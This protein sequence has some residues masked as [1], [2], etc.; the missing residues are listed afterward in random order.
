M[1]NILITLLI[2][3]LSFSSHAQGNTLKNA[4][5][6]FDVYAFS[7]AASLYEQALFEE[8]NANKHMVILSKLGDC[9]YNISDSKNAAIWYNRAITRFPDIDSEYL[10]KYVQTLRSI[11]K[12]Q[13]ANKILV[14]YK[15]RQKDDS[16]AEDFEFVNL[17][18]L[19][20]PN[21]EKAKQVELTNLNSNTENSDFS[22]YE[23]NGKFFFSSA[24]RI[25]LDWYSKKDKIYKW[26]K[27]PYLN[28]YE[29]TIEKTNG[30]TEIIDIT[31]IPSDSLNLEIQHE[32][33]SALTKDGNT[34]Y[35]TGN[36]VNKQGDRVND[37]RGTSNLMLYRA[38]RIND[39]WEK[40][41]KLPF[42]NVDF[43]TGHPT[44]SPDE[45]TLYFVSDNDKLP[46]A[47]GQTDLYK[48]QIYDDGSFGEVINLKAVNTVHREMF[49]FIAADSTLYFSS[50]GHATGLLDIFKSDILKKADGEPVTRE[51]L[52]APYNSGADD[53]AYFTND[54]G[55]TGY[56]SSNRDGGVGS[57]D[58]YAFRQEDPCEQII[59]GITYGKAI[60]DID[61]K[62]LQ[63]VL[64]ELKD[65]AGNIIAS[66]TSN[67]NGIYVFV[68]LIMKKHIRFLVKK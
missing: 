67:E 15:E 64:V 3:L 32:G 41:E 9:F 63:G 1:K 39:K 49:P 27:E 4:D 29:G 43:S 61:S 37:G 20:D 54:N 53:F 22:G 10:W 42:N 52:G 47:K 62:P 65:Q 50:D 56:F 60:T 44:L 28:V 30:V 2:S 45:N 57:D 68:G 12:Y 24:N 19:L 35:F 11:G 6:A 36:N 40:V 38:I 55:K 26:N 48:V 51:N 59:S 8:K 25:G 21:S 31:K 23:L 33:T 34:L 58:I 14:I 16:R 5:E 13:E 17:K 18:S 46:D 7:E 66:T